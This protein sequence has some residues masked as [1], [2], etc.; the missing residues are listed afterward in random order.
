MVSTIEKKRA[1]YDALSKVVEII[2]TVQ[3]TSF[4]YS[5]AYLIVGFKL[6]IFVIDTCKVEIYEE[7]CD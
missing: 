2:K 7:N 5:L 6:R 1:V 3:F 4:Q